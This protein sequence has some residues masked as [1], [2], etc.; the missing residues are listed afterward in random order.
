MRYYS[1]TMSFQSHSCL[2][3]HSPMI[4]RFRLK[5]YSLYEC[6][7][8]GYQSFFPRPKSTLSFYQQRSY[9]HDGQKFHLATNRATHPIIDVE[10]LPQYR[11]LTKRVAR[12][13]HGS[14]LLDVG[15]G[16]GLFV[17][18][19]EKKGIKAKGIDIS[20]SGIELA[21]TLTKNCELKDF[22]REEK[23]VNL[24]YVTMFDVIE[25]VPNPRDFF[26]KASSSL[27]KGGY[28]I[29]TTPCADSIVRKIFGRHWHLYTPPRHL[30]IF[31][32]RSIAQLLRES[33]LEIVSLKKE[34]QY[35]NVG[36]IFGKLFKLHN[37]NNKVINKVLKLKFIQDMNIYLNLFDVVT[38]WAKKI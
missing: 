30:Q 7:S 6:C 18:L 19:C 15:C 26:A 20:R 29:F 23:S 5:G 14:R 11:T 21:R 10:R 16:S 2:V 38:T 31:S 32:I 1:G 33:G 9:F 17:H 28:F 36:Y 25:H 27:R 13:K 3:C 37:I 4:F 35:T 34:G 22:I 8:C 24:D 12:L